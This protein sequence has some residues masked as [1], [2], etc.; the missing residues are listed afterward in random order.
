MDAVAGL[1]AIATLVATAFALSTWERYLSRRAPHQLAWTVSLAMFAVASAAYTWGA[2]LGW[3]PLSFRLFYLF[4]A[5]LNVP[6]L[7]LGTIYL[8]AGHRIGAA[9]HRP[10]DLAAAAVTGVLLAA[11][12]QAEVPVDGLPSG[13]EIFGI[14]PR[15]MAAVGSGLGATVL[16]VGA[17]WSAVRLVRSRRLRP[18]VRPEF[19]VGPGR[20]AVTNGLI[21]LGSLVLGIGGAGFTGRDALVAFGVFLVSGIVILFAGFLVSTPPRVGAG[22]AMEAVD[23][24][25]IDELAAIAEAA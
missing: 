18:L 14:G 9:L 15:I 11:P 23:R 4:G 10:L 3:N 1:G 20:L 17:I 21:A 25:F 5:I 22:G 8:L 12:L 19:G 7:A 24:A 2:G 13:R 6:Y 16:I